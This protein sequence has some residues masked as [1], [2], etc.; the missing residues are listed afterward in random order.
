MRLRKGF[1]GSRGI[2]RMLLRGIWQ[3]FTK[4]KWQGK[5][6]NNPCD[7]KRVKGEKLRRSRKNVLEKA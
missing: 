1:V 5:K 2:W 3:D 7:G 6:K 4:G